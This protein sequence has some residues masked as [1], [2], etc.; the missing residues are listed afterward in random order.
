VPPLQKLKKIK[1]KSE[2]AMKFNFSYIKRKKEKK[3]F[4]FS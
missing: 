1:I 2:N 4:Y 3:N